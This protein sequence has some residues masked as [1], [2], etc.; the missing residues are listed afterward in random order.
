MERFQKQDSREGISLYRSKEKLPAIIEDFSEITNRVLK[1][2]T[3]QEF[4]DLMILHEEKLGKFL[5]LQT[6]K[7]KHFPDAPVFLKSLGAWGGDFVLSQKFPAY[8]A[9]F[10]EKGFSRIFDF[11]DIIA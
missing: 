4:S 5:G 8:E 7:E 10:G 2:E 1:A 9:Y 11:K 3:L 6:V